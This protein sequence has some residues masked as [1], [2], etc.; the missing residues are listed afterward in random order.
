MWIAPGSM[1]DVVVL[2]LVLKGG[3]PVFAEKLTK[4]RSLK[5]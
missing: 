2:V 5:A 1:D 3:D 4:S